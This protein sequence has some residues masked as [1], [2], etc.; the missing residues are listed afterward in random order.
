M[1]FKFFVTLKAAD[2]R[3]THTTIPTSCI[4]TNQ[5]PDF[6]I[7]SKSDDIQSLTII[8][9]TVPFELN[10]EKAH[11]MKTDKYASLVNDLESAGVETAFIALEIGA[12]GYINNENLNRLKDSLKIC[13][14]NIQFKN[15]RN[16][17]SK[18]ALISSFVIFNAKDE[19][20]WNENVP[21]L[22]V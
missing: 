10:A 12:R 4:V 2:R 5:I 8:E 9:L 16:S 3:M 6:C 17:L 15:F 1:I 14:N 20:S 18:L 22:N 19:P 13:S 21:L 11:K 7:F